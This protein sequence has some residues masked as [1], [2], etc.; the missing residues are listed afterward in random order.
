MERVGDDERDGDRDQADDEA[1]AQLAEM[2]DERRLL[3]VAQ[4]PRKQAHRLSDRTGGGG[5]SSA[6]GPAAARGLSSSLPVTES[7]NSRIPRAE[8]AADLRQALRAEDEQRHDEDDDQPRDSDLRHGFSV[9]RLGT[10]RPMRTPRRSR[11]PS[12][13][14]SS[15]APRAGS[16]ARS[17]AAPARRGAK[18]VVTARNGEALDDAVREIEAF[19]SEALAVPADHAVAGRGRARSSSRRSTGSGGSTRTSP[20]RW[21]R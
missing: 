7:L 6:R 13:S 20:T 19:G 1:R 18:V 8:R 15:P 3:A 2:L 17:P 21:S 4:A 5:G 16:A 12:R 9:A 10:E 14:S 11:S